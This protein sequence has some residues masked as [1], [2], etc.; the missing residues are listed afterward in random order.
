MSMTEEGFEIMARALADDNENMT[1]EEARALAAL[2]GD[3]PEEDENGMVV[4]RDG[5][6]KVIRRLHL[7][8]DDGEDVQ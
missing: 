3:T 8:W 6:G 2:I 1:I 7:P 4:L 5:R